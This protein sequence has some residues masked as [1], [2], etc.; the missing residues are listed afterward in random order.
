[1]SQQSYSMDQDSIQ[2]ITD[3]PEWLKAMHL[4][5]FNTAYEYLRN[6]V[7]SYV[8]FI[9]AEAE[10]FDP[11][12]KIGLSLDVDRRYKEITQE[13]DKGL[14]PDWLIMGCD[15]L[16]ILGM[17]EGTQP[18]ETALHKAFTTKA[19][20]REWFNYDDDMQEAIDSILEDYCQCKRCLIADSITYQHPVDN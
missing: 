3:R 11:L 18:L 2:P 5:W 4:G 9:V 10:G 20:G 17:V 12:V 19:I 15:N 6:P 8:Y 1:M 7:K 16:R 13:I 14:Y